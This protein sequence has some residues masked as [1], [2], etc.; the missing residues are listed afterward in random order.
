[1][2]KYKLG[3]LNGDD[4][5]LEV[6]P[7]AVQVIQSATKKY[8]LIDIEWLNLPVGYPAYKIGRAHV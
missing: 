7:V 8:P 2:G 5:G 3:I 1:M 4:I 6:V